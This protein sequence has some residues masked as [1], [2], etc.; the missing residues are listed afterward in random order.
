LL[1][2]VEV[3]PPMPVLRKVSF[4]AG[5]RVTVHVE[6]TVH[7]NRVLTMIR[8][9][10]AVP[11]V[12]LNPATPLVLLEDVLDLVGLVLVMSVNPGFG[13]QHYLPGATT[14]IQRLAE[15][16]AARGLDYLIEVDG[17][18]HPETIA[19]PVAAGCDLFV[20]GSAIFNDEASV[21]ANIAA[22]QAEITR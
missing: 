13:G 20:A 16:R 2:P 7:L 9:A 19:P 14:R 17:G 22:L 10:G 8:D 21:A 1:P 6:A 15:L 3:S 18:I 5:K 12:T 4:H 11:G